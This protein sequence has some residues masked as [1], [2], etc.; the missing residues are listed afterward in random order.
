MCRWTIPVGLPIPVSERDADKVIVDVQQITGVAHSVA[1]LL[2]NNRYGLDFYQREYGWGEAQVVEFIDDLAGR[3]LDEFNPDHKREDVASYR[4]YFL[5]PIVTELRDGVRYLVDGQQRITTLSLLLI[6]LRRSLA[7]KHS[8][9]ANSL[10]ALIFTSAFG[11][12]TFNLD[13]DER[14]E[15]LTAILEDR[16]FDALSE[17]DSVRNLWNRYETITE[18]F[19]SEL[20]DVALP[21]FVDWLLHRVILVD[22]VAPDQEMALEIFETMNDRG[23]RLSNTDMLKGFL[24]AR[25]G[26]ENLIRSLNDRWKR[27]ITELTDVEENAD[28]D[29]IKAWL[30]SKYA[31]T[32]RE[33][34]ANASPGDFDV[35]HT[36]FHKWVRDNSGRIGIGKQTEFRE[37]VEQEFFG[38]SSRYLE[39]LHASQEFQTGLEAVYYNARTGFT[40]QFLVILAAVKSDDDDATFVAKAALVANALDVFVV[41]RMVNFRNFGYN[42]VV[43]KMFNLAKRIRNRSTSEVQEL[44]AE[45]LEG[46]HERLD[47]I[48][49]FRLTMRNRRHIM[50]LLARITAWLDNELKTSVTFVDYIDRSGKNPYQ[51]EHIWADHFE[52]HADEFDNQY[53]FED[54]RNKFGDLLLLPGDF[55][56]SFGDM[57]YLE[58]VAHYNAQNPLA[59]SLNPLAHQN[60][61][62]FL[63][64]CETHNLAFVAYPTTFKKE[65]IDE[66]Q[67]LYRQLAEIVWDPIRLGLKSC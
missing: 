42:T 53:E 67:E 64:L 4:P 9:D 18:Q 24:L 26:E 23:L 39:L 35:I 59:R 17:G 49:S 50:Y 55:N 5:G 22:I 61:P 14:E 65:N 66:R 43:Y 27:R 63:R 31:E 28:A 10:E 32:Q 37:F 20:H 7:E 12:K 34:K 44:L 1:Q 51:I 46:E 11:R 45:W 6:Y 40:L 15:C 13:V 33:R 8:Q 52:R 19:S 29:F 30:R 62:S 16:E 3:F 47:G 60:N 21:Y 56:A 48:H 36:A 25:V 58:K 2:S 57:P 54:H 38:L 41:R